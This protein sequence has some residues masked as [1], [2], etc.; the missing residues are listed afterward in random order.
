MDDSVGKQQHESRETRRDSDKTEE[1]RGRELGTNK[2]RRN[3]VVLREGFLNAPPQLV[4]ISSGD[5]A[6]HRTDDMP[7]R[8]SGAGG[9]REV[10]VSV[11][12]LQD[13]SG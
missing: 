2:Q 8:R 6:V 11:N 5:A 4:V 9:H 12:E 3:L 7:P 10:D 1:T 13:P